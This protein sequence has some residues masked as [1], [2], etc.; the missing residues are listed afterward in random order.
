MQSWG[1]TTEFEDETVVASQENKELM[2]LRVLVEWVG[3]PASNLNR[4]RTCCRL[5]SRGWFLHSPNETYAL[6]FADLL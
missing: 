2:I 4:G 6:G 1:W 3:F 5:E